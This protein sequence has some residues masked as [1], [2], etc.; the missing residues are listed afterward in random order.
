MGSLYQFLR[1]DWASLEQT[2]PVL[3]SRFDQFGQFEGCC[4][5]VCH[6]ESGYRISIRGFVR[7]FVDPPRGTMGRWDDSGGGLEKLRHKVLD[8][9][10]VD[11]SANIFCD[12][13]CYGPSQ[14][15]G[16]RI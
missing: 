16:P 8:G 3:K 13:S 15:V 11:A 12:T 9:H 7:R 10:L 2:W 1:A 5:P 6:Q 14:P 4:L